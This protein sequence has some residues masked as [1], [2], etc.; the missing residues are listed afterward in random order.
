MWYEMNKPIHIDDPRFFKSTANLR[1]TIRVAVLT[2]ESDSSRGIHTHMKRALASLSNALPTMW[3]CADSAIWHDMRKHSDFE[4]E[5]ILSHGLRERTSPALLPIR[6]VYKL[7]SR[8]EER[9]CRTHNPYNAMNI[10]VRNKSLHTPFIH[11]QT[12]AEW[13]EIDSWCSIA[14]IFRVWEAPACLCC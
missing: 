13:F 4:H 11:M 2:Q 9:R 3:H 8:S 5:V 12:T 6:N 10:D 14:K 7:K 1:E